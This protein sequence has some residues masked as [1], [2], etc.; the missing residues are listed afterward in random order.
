MFPLAMEA[1]SLEDFRPLIKNK[2]CPSRRYYDKKIADDLNACPLCDYCFDKDTLRPK[3][4]R[5]IK[6]WKKRVREKEL[7]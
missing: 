2:L 6:R 5:T 4:E 3:L 7:A 1:K